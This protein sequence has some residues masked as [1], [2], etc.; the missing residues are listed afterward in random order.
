MK[1]IKG[2]ALV[3]LASTAMLGGIILGSVPAS[4]AVD[5]TLGDVGTDV[6]VGFGNGSRGNID[7][8]NTLGLNYI[9]SQI[10]FGTGHV[11]GT[12]VARQ[13][14]ITPSSDAYIALSDDRDRT[15]GGTDF[16]WKLTASASPLENSNR[17]KVINS[18]NITLGLGGT[19]RWNVVLDVPVSDPGTPQ[20]GQERP[21]PSA[22]TVDPGDLNP[23][24][25]TTTNA[26]LPL[27]G[28]H[29]EIARM[30]VS[31]R[32]GYAVKLNSAQL[33]LAATDT[34][35]SFHAG[36]NYSGKIT[37]TLSDTI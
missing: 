21:E 8:T 19:H 32:K 25:I 30:A 27:D 2:K 29:V 36:T 20:P 16:E 10:D 1:T 15:G 7:T 35:S 31:E 14:N 3:G 5:S 17:T 24:V 11:A 13:G 6:T 4:A 26:V 12:A 33:N 34:D 9:P 22:T 28:T 37:W 18:G 23:D